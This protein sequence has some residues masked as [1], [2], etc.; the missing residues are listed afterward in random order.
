[1]GYIGG[2]ELK[3]CLGFC[4]TLF[5]PTCHDDEEV[6]MGMAWSGVA[7]MK[8][9]YRDSNT[10]PP[11]YFDHRLLHRHHQQGQHHQDEGAREPAGGAHPEPPAAKVKLLTVRLELVS[12]AV[13]LPQLEAVLSGG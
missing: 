3:A 11:A 9:S 12:A 2:C 7:K 13:G 6:R 10:G 4:L 1:M 5:S 8:Y